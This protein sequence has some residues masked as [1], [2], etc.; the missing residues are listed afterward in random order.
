MRVRLGVGEVITTILMNFVGIY[1][2]AF[3]VVG[4]LQE[5]R[6]VFNQTDPIADA[7]RLPL[8]VEGTRLHLG[9]LL[10]VVLGV[11]MWATLRWTRIGFEIRAVGAAPGA[12]RVA[13][14]ISP[15]RVVLISFLASG[16][17]AGLAGGVEVAGVT[18]ALYE[19]LSPGWGYTA[20]AVALLGGLHPIAVI[21]TGLLFGALEGGA[22]EMQ[23]AAG[24][25]SSWVTAVEAL[26]ILS[27]LAVDQ[28]RRRQR[29]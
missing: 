21:G 4:P 26:V 25:P 19:G 17:I 1:L 5:A 11:G 6:G 22:A 23:R 18:F 20:I 29:A 24:I 2:A 27:V 14:M 8:L 3:M 10:A 7:A 28:V 16:A 9:F 12:A 15:D 13:G